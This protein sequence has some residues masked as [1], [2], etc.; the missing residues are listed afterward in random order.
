MLERDRIDL[1]IWISIFYGYE[2]I[3]V[4]Y[5]SVL[6]GESNK[7]PKR[8]D[9]A[10]QGHG[11]SWSRDGLDRKSLM[12]LEN[13]EIQKGRD[14]GQVLGKKVVTARCIEEGCV[15]IWG[16]NG[17]EVPG[18]SNLPGV[19]TQNLQCSRK[20][21]EITAT[22]FFFREENEIKTLIIEQNVKY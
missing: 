11:M 5:Q 10:G 9:S 15:V 19:L 12:E 6:G 1:S 22:I 21:T 20:L 3:L 17:C 14:S 7:S 4:V 13:H 2:Q 16:T 8:W 18:S